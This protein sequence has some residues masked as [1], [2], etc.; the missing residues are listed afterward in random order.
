MI[1]TTPTGTLWQ[2]Q[3]ESE[4]HARPELNPSSICA[5]L[6]GSNEVDVRLIR[7]TLTGPR[8]ATAQASQDRMDRGSVVHMALLQPERLETD[9]AVWTGGRRA[10]AEWDNFEEQALAN[11]Q[12][13][14]R[15]S[16]YEAARSAADEIAKHPV[17]SQLL[18][19]CEPEV[20]ML[21]KW[22]GVDVRGMV[23]AVD[24]AG[25]RI[26]DVKTTD[27]GISEDQVSRTVRNM[28]YR[29]KMAAYRMWIA[30]ITGTVA[31]DWQCWNLFLCMS[32]P[33]G[34]RKCKFTTIS[35]EFGEVRVN[36]AITRY[37]RAMDA[38]EWPLFYADDVIDVKPWE[39]PDEEADDVDWS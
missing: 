9:V 16:D 8:P 13:L 26:I 39:M 38:N 4:Y 12:L 11:N 34:I 2:P 19:G 10:G 23:D 7:D 14:M 18:N 17:V 29:E 20:A 5:G 24:I 32:P 28:H 6:I 31:S 37:K 30:H 21:T 35:L 27:A 33:Y 22:L 36:D 25:K 15:L 1:H 3:I